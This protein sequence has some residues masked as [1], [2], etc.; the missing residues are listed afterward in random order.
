MSNLVSDI[1]IANIHD[2]K[3]LSDLSSVTFF[4]TFAHVNKKEDMDKYLSENFNF[5]QIKNEISDDQNLFYI[6]FSGLIIIGYAKLRK[7]PEPELIKEKRTIEIERLY[8]LRAF[9]NQ[10][11]GA[12]LMAKCLNYA[13]ENYYETVWLGV[14]E[15]NHNAISFYKRWGFTTFDSH[16]FLLGTDLQTDLLMKKDLIPPLTEK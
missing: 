8:V 16:P 9:Q 14:W 5:N 3:T 1:R 11:V 7:S 6:A 10:Q 4:E 12:S 2:T 15:H 13:K